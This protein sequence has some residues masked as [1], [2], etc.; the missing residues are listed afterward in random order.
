[1]IGRNDINLTGPRRLARRTF[2]PELARAYQ[3]RYVD[4]LAERAALVRRERILAAV[5]HPARW[6]VRSRMEAANIA[7]VVA[8]QHI[9]RPTADTTLAALGAFLRFLRIVDDEAQALAGRVYYATL[10]E[11]AR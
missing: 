6:D 5:N 8:R 10:A 2:G 4:P 3:R 9:E 11:A 7:R 1:M